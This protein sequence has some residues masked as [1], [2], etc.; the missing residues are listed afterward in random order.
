[1]TVV[2]VLALVASIAGSLAWYAYNRNVYFSFVG[3]SVAKSTLINVGLVDDDHYLSDSKVEQ[4]ELVR[5]EVD[6]HSI[7]FTHSSKGFSVQAIREYLFQSPYAVSM[8]YP[9]TTQER[10]LKN[11]DDSYNNSDLTL[12]RAPE[13]GDYIISREATKSD[14]V[15]LPFAFKISDTD[16]NNIKNTDIWLTDASTQASGENIDQSVRVF[17]HNKTSQRKFLMKPADST[18]TQGETKV[19]GLLDLD[20][21]GTYDYDKSNGN[22]YYYG[23]YEEA[24]ITNAT[25]KYNVPFDDAPFENVNGVVGITPTSQASTFYAKHNENAYCV[26]LKDVGDNPLVTPKVA[27]YETFGTVNPSVLSNGDYY[28]GAT[29]IPV[30]NTGNTTG[31]G[32]VDFTIFIE[33]WD[34]VVIDRAIGYQFNL[35]LRF[36]INRL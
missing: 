8:L 30:A 25:T 23:Q 24:S 9:L 21:D 10:H 1:M 15:F 33:G 26:N 4:Y 3:T 14:Y 16:G 27:E 17:I 36:E 28:A 2:S 19:G 18:T 34:H 32:Y 20:G 11:N 31:I 6:G 5:E 12:Y 13:Y 22:E 7:V 29:G 35:G